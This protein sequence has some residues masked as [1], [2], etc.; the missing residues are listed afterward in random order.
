VEVLV[1]VLVL[2]CV[3]VS[4]AVWWTTSDNIILNGSRIGGFQ[5]RRGP[6]LQVRNSG[7]FVATSLIPP[8]QH[9][10]EC[11][12][13][14]RSEPEARAFKPAHIERLTTRALSLAA[15]LRV[16]GETL[17]IYL[18]VIAPITIATLGLLRTWLPL[19][20][21]LFGWLV[22][23]VMLYRRAWRRLYKDVP[24]GWRSD[25]ALMLL[26]P[27]GAVRA[28]DKLTRHAL[29]GG[30]L[31]V[32]SVI[33]APREFCRLARLLY[34]DQEAPP[35]ADVHEEINTILD[36]RGLRA[37]FEEAPVP[38]PGMLGFCRRCHTQLMRDS[39]GCPDCVGLSITPFSNR[40]GAVMRI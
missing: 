5:A 22:V 17:W 15:P 7:G 9:S 12:L 27:P 36:T 18:F 40:S 35:S 33:A 38:E 31:R 11:A 29:R 32:T 6:S 24:S 37:M 2:W 16:L 3:Y 10:F 19:L 4:D 28:A 14:G 26:S 20:A 30:G 1:F 34:F 23:I 13:D 39:G 21:I 8:F 25:A